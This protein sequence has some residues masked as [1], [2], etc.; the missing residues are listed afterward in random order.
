MS[1]DYDADKN[2]KDGHALAVSEMRRGLAG[3]DEQ[4]IAAA[5]VQ[6][7]HVAL[8]SV[9]IGEV[10]A[11]R[12]KAAGF[13]QYA[14]AA[15]LGRGLQNDIAEAKVTAECKAGLLLRDVPREKGGRPAE[16]SHQPDVS[17]TAY[18]SAL[19]KNEIPKPTAERWQIMA[20]LL[21]KGGLQSYFEKT[22][23]KE[24]P[25]DE[26]TSSDVFRLGKKLIPYKTTTATPVDGKY[27]TIIID[28]PW[29]MQRI[30][31]QEAKNQTGFDYGVMS[32]DE[33]ADSASAKWSDSYPKNIAAASAHCWLWT[34][35]KFLPDAFNLMALWGFKYIFTEVWHK[36]G[37][38]QPFGLPQYNCEFVLFGRRGGLEFETTRNFFCCFNAPRRE[39][40]RKP[41][42]FYD[43]VRR[44]SPSRRLDMFSREHREG[45]DSWGN[46]TEAFDA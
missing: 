38:F 21:E 2:A 42:E 1:D 41:D 11:I 32:I 8:A 27:Q 6:M 9:D 43:M 29:P 4:Q 10:K 7:K 25:N 36:P 28:P 33:L 45:F 44:V 5:V 17:F 30:E 37:G 35:H 15:K 23:K 39:H 18:Q 24:P 31:R 22:R 14:Q 20:W 40:S 26:I 16:N 19:D 3:A 34:T 46:Q 12:D 13:E